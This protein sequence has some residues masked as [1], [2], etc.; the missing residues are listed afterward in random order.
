[1]TTLLF[2]RCLLSCLQTTRPTLIRLR[3]YMHRTISPMKL[4]YGKPGKFVRAFSESPSLLKCAQRHPDYHK[5]TLPA[6]IVEAER[7]FLCVRRVKTWL[8]VRSIMASYRQSNLCMLHCHQ[9]RVDEKK[10]NINNF[11]RRKETTNG[12]LSVIAS[13][14][15]L[16]ISIELE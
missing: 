16:Y 11:G 6:T 10:A 13:I 2:L 8:P 14:D 1:M 3:A 15:S 9:K 12:L 4:G 7:S 5:V